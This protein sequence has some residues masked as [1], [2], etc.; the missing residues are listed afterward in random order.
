MREVVA[1]VWNSPLDNR[2]FVVVVR[3]L[4]DELRLA[5]ELSDAGRE[6]GCESRCVVEHPVEIVAHSHHF[7]ARLH[8]HEL[9]VHRSVLCAAA[10]NRH[11]EHFEFHRLLEPFLVHSLVRAHIHLDD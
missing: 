6:F 2:L 3:K 10:V 9:I 4:V 11:L 8:P 5:F 1:Q 7:E